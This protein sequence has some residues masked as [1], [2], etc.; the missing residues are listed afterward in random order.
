MASKNEKIFQWF[1]QGHFKSAILGKGAYFIPDVTYRDHHDRLLIFQQ[2]FLWLKDN[3]TKFQHS[4]ILYDCLVNIIQSENINDILDVVWC[5]LLIAEEQHFQ[6]G[7]ETENIELNLAD[8]V[9]KHG[10]RIAES[11]EL[12]E[13]VL[14]LAEKL[15]NFKKMLNL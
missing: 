2:L 3:Q 14:T 15:P 13:L 4:E 12:R 9:I 6:L 1:D 11:S 8:Q 10:A 5:Y 7:K